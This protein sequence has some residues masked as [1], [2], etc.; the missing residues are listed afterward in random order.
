MKS[1]AFFSLI[2]EQTFW[3]SAPVI[4]F[5]SES[6]PLLFFCEFIKLL[7]RKN[8]ILID[9]LK[10]LNTNILYQSFLGQRKTYWLGNALEQ[11]KLKERR[12]YEKFLENYSGP[13]TICLF[14]TDDYKFSSSMKKNIKVI[15]FEQRVDQ[16]KVVEMAELFEVKNVKQKITLVRHIFQNGGAISFDDACFL[17]RYFEVTNVPLMKVLI[18]ETD[19]FGKVSGS[20]YSLSQYFFSKQ[21]KQFFSL[22]SS[23]SINYPETFWVSYWIDQLWRAYYV[24]KF[25]HQ[26]K[27][28]EAKRISFKLP[29][30]F[31]N[32]SWRNCSLKEL[33]NACGFV[34]NIDY[35]LKRGSTFYSL[36][37]FFCNYFQ[38]VFRERS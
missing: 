35:A 24:V 38:G 21:E 8:I 1:E 25:L 32:S 37:L 14:V 26:N 27:I 11:I 10:D 9:Q 2:K 7:K 20:L 16:K 30:S 17:I 5:K 13:N 22:W 28:N 12:N 4:C 19:V 34:Y 29:F 15:D 23:M 6:Y 31:L 3:D 33:I 18:N 36:D